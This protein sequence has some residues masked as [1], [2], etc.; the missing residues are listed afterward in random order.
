MPFNCEQYGFTESDAYGQAF[1]LAVLIYESTHL[2]VGERVSDT[3]HH[4]NCDDYIAAY[5]HCLVIKGL[6]DGLDYKSGASDEWGSWLALDSYQGE[7]SIARFQDH[8]ARHLAITFSLVPLAGVNLEEDERWSTLNLDALSDDSDEKDRYAEAKGTWAGM[9]PHLNLDEAFD[10]AAFEEKDRRA[11][12]SGT[13]A[14]GITHIRYSDFLVADQ[15]AHYNSPA[16]NGENEVDDDKSW[17]PI[18]RMGSSEK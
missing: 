1:R 4:K 7:F 11:K 16:F 15:K 12:V 6:V 10:D 18:P 5:R 2:S 13:K 8:Y 14:R 17:Q 9:I 3:V